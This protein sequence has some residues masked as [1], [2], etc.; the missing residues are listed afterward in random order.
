MTLTY[1][2]HF[3]VT[4]CVMCITALCSIYSIHYNT[5]E[6]TLFINIYIL[7]VTLIVNTFSTRLGNANTSYLLMLLLIA[8]IINNLI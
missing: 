7:I 8:L 1:V 4:L 3:T 2:Y 6:V 5:I